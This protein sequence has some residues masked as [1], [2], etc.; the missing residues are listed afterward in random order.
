MQALGEGRERAPEP[1]GHEPQVT[2]LAPPRTHTGSPALTVLRGGNSSCQHHSSSPC[3][4]R[5][6]RCTHSTRLHQSSLK[7]G[8]LRRAL[9]VAAW[10]GRAGEK[11]HDRAGRCVL[12]LSRVSA[13][14][15]PRGRHGAAGALAYACVLSWGDGVAP[16]ETAVLPSRPGRSIR[17][18][19]WGSGEVFRQGTPQG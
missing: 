13:S 16:T 9:R 7:S 18:T 12:L 5:S 6:S 8:L 1:A 4:C 14:T 11:T 10:V 3:L 2:H 17:P 19:H 15:S